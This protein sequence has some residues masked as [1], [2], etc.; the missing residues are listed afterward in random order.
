VATRA[1]PLGAT[2]A[3][4]VAAPAPPAKAPRR[5][6]ETAEAARA[7][8]VVY[9]LLTRSAIRP[10]ALLIRRVALPTRSRARPAP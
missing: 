4:G 7:G 1:H 2:L 3:R 5:P 6:A 9:P 8:A 10:A